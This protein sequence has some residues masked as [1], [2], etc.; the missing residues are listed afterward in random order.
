MKIKI[1]SNG[2][3][4]GTRIVN[5]ETN[6]PIEGCVAVHW[7]CDM[8]ENQVATAIVEF[9]NVPVEIVG[10]MAIGDRECIEE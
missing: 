5:A 1:I 4:R 10:E 6:E 9:L 7:I 3:P 2:I 8:D